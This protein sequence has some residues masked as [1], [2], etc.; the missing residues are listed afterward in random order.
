MASLKGKTL[1]ISGA[2]RGIGLAIALRAARDGTAGAP[3][4]L[5]ELVRRQADHALAL[6]EWLLVCEAE[7]TYRPPPAVPPLP[8]G[9]AIRKGVYVRAGAPSFYVSAIRKMTTQDLLEWFVGHRGCP[10]EESVCELFSWTITCRTLGV[11][12]TS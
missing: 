5:Y 1:F 8:T 9:W 2:S 11:E 3:T 6:S 10:Q 4:P 12:P 7:S